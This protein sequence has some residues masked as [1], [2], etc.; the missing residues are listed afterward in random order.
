MFALESPPDW[1][2]TRIDRVATVR[3]RI[4]WKALTADEYVDDGY[5]FLSTPNIKNGQIDF[6]DVNRIPS[7]RYEESPELKLRPGDVLLAKDGNTLGITNVVDELPEPATV[8]GSIAVLRPHAIEPRYLRY[9]LASE[10]IQG[11]IAMLK[12]G[13]G[14]PHLFQRDINRLPVLLPP[15]GAQR[16]IA[17]FLDTET[18]RLGEVLLLRGQQLAIM[19]VRWRAHLDQ[20][21]DTLTRRFGAAPL[22]RSLARIEQ[23]TSPQCENFPA[24]EG[25]WGVLKAGAVKGD[26]FLPWENKRLPESLAPEIRYEIHAG[27]LLVTRA[28]TP[29][30]VGA[31]AVVPE[32]VRRGLILCDKIFRL[33]LTTNLEPRFVSLLSQASA[34]R[35]ARASA[36]TGTSSSMVN[37]TNQDV[38]AWPI[39]TAPIDVQREVV[40]E[41]MGARASQHDLELALVAQMDLLR[42]RRQAVITAA[43]TGQIDVTGVRSG[44]A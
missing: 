24:P 32:G 20:V 1:R 34:I 29:A 16:R 36:A 6:T 9:W 2:S 39:P 37:L 30:L 38:K 21:M 23:G 33:T 12:G 15:S 26:R 7:W 43:V 5:A 25:E 44:A 28:N 22:G 3:A 41:L 27:D 8:N 11:E 4:G 17:D 18:A 40:D 19:P 31:A 35:D 10:A 14:V 42:E 13:M